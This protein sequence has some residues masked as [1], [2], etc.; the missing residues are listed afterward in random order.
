VIRREGDSLFVD[1]PLTLATVSGL[2]N[3]TRGHLLQG[4]RVIDFRG[5]SEVDSSAVALALEWLR[6][7]GE[8]KSGLRFVNLPVAMQNLAKLYGVSALLQP[9][10]S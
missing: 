4:A 8:G 6:Q 2:A 7:A 9:S 1:G 5:V 3:E 10:A